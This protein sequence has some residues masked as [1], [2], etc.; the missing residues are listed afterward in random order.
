MELNQPNNKLEKLVKNIAI[1]FCNLENIKEYFIGNYIQ[2]FY[3]D[4]HDTDQMV[5]TCSI[6]EIVNGYNE[7]DLLDLGLELFASKFMPLLI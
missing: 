2:D 1:C 6:K 4:Y 7:P 3:N 5:L